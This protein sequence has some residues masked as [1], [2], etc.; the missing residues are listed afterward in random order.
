MTE[1]QGPGQRLNRGWIAFS[2]VGGIALVALA[3]IV[4]TKWGWTGVTTEALVEGGIALAFVGLAFLFERRFV[5]GIAQAASAAAKATVAAQTQNIQ[6]R[7]DDLTDAVQALNR[8]EA[9]QQDEVISLLDEPTFENVMAALQEAVDLRALAGS[10]ARVNAVAEPNVLGLSFGLTHDQGS[11]ILDIV[12]RP[13]ARARSQ[14]VGFPIL[15]WLPSQSP[16]DVGLDISR[17]IMREGF[18]DNPNDFDWTQALKN[19]K[20]SIDTAV[21][22][23]RGDADAWRLHGRLYE[24]LTEDWAV[25]TAGLEYRPRPAYVLDRKEFPQTNG[26]PSGWRPPAEVKAALARQCP[27][28][29]D[30]NEWDWLVQRAQEYF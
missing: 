27:E 13:Y 16:T 3:F 21:R 26:P 30:P 29:C 28:W 23:R 24:L 8:R 15:K 19:F 17:T 7:I 25:T 22:S 10:R 11:E 9:Q 12:I 2:C 5:G 20:R 14:P 6:N 4:Q 1:Q 18:L